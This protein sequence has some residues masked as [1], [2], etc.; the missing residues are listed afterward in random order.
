MHRFDWF[1]ILGLSAIAAGAGVFWNS[2]YF[3]PVKVFVVFLHEAS[4]ALAALATGGEVKEMRVLLQEAGIVQSLGGSPFWTLMA[5][6]L[7]S[8]LWGGVL[9]VVSSRTK[10]AKTLAILLGMGMLALTLLYMANSS[11]FLFGVGFGTA[12][13]L[14][15]TFLP[16]GVAEWVL[17][18][19][20]LISCLYAIYDI[21]SDI[22]LNPSQESDA[23][24]IAEQ[25]GFPPFL[26]ETSRT[27]FWGILWMVLALIGT[28]I[29]L[30]WALRPSKSEREFL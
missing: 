9:L 19:L 24:L 27:L 5:G 25:T 28:W 17:R 7:G 2:P 18:G 8:L 15:G 16:K 13:I 23:S 10:W 30:A 12:L 29:F 3:T 26:P 11:G 21:A 14:I 6:Y 22:L 20:G 1:K 4:H